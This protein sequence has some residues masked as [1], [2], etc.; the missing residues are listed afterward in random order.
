VNVLVLLLQL[1]CQP[2]ADDV[3]DA[4]TR[5]VVRDAR[6][7][8]IDLL[9]ERCSAD[10]RAELVQIAGAHYAWPDSLSSQLFD[11]DDQALRCHAMVALVHREHIDARYWNLA[12]LEL[13]AAPLTH[14]PARDALDEMLADSVPW[15]MVPAWRLIRF[16]TEPPDPGYEPPPDAIATAP[17][18]IAAE[19]LTRFP[20]V[21]RVPELRALAAGGGASAE[22]ARAALERLSLMHR[23][24]PGRRA[25]RLDAMV[26]EGTS[27]A[28]ERMVDFVGNDMPWDDGRPPPSASEAHELDLHVEGA[29]RWLELL[30]HV[31]Y[32]D[33]R[34]CL[35]VAKHAIVEG[36]LGER[37]FASFEHFAP[38]N[39]VRILMIF[40]QLARPGTSARLQDIAANDPD[41]AVRVEARFA[42]DALQTGGWAAHSHQQFR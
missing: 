9:G 28:F 38:A 30:V 25:Q 27:A 17:A 10:S 4:L 32:A 2:Q 37:L 36:S 12:F 19:V 20:V 39:R 13:G 41:P 14:G 5:A 40:E 16:P 18:E 11:T 3:S 21:E 8:R 6:Q 26:A 15:C 35:L 29:L 33:R 31:P 22:T 24:N 1:S 23:Q 42:I 34:D 7:T